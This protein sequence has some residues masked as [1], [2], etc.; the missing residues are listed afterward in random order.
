MLWFD[1]KEKKGQE[2][3]TARLPELPKLPELPRIGEDADD[4][5][6]DTIHQLPRFPNSPIGEKFSRKSIKD[7]I[8]G[9]KEDTEAFEADEPVDDEELQEMQ[10]PL[11]K[12]LTREIFSPAQKWKKYNK[13]IPEEFEGVRRTVKDAEPVFIR[14][15]KFEDSMKI[16]AKAKQQIYEIEKDLKDIKT[17]KEQEERELSSWE[18]EISNIKEKIEKVNQDIFSKI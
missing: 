7:A 3:E 2:F 13:K 1:K 16:F 18:N 4:Y 5:S 11:K 8:T 14:L 6:L 12:S 9:E 17:L 10:E 15:D